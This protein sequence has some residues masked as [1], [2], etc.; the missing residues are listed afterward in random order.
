MSTFIEEV[1]NTKRL[2]SSLG[3]VPP[4]EFEMTHAL[5]HRTSL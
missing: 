3:Y 2:H 5:A 1:D 4:C